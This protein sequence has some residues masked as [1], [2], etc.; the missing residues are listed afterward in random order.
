MAVLAPRNLH[1]GVLALAVAGLFSPA[2]SIG[3][4]LAAGPE[5]K[6]LATVGPWSIGQFAF[7]GGGFACQ[8]AQGPNAV[9]FV[10]AVNF[11]RTGGLTAITGM[12]IESAN[13]FYPMTA[14]TF[15]TID[16]GQRQAG[17]LAEGG[18]Q[19]QFADA[20][21]FFGRSTLNM[22]FALRDMA[23]PVRVLF[24]ISKL[25]EAVEWFRRP[26]CQPGF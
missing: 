26:E 22:N 1:L 25:A 19:M 17:K 11:F 14:D 6:I 13:A 16:T 23:Q 3:D 9:G 8:V 10:L 5:K 24:D 7:P 18:D 2:L 21:E 12:W 15:Y 4:A 20:T